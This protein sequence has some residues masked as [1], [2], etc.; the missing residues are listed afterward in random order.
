M[1]LDSTWGNEEVKRIIQNLCEKTQNGSISWECDEYNPASFLL[2]DEYGEG[3]ERKPC[4][5]HIVTL[6]YEP[7]GGARY[8]LEIGG[9]IQIDKNAPGSLH[10]KLS[11]YDADETL[12][13]QEETVIDE[14]EADDFGFIPLCGAVF[15]RAGEWLNEDSFT[16]VDDRHFYP[17]KGVTKK[18]RATPLC[19]L[20]E[21]LMNE[22][23]IG[24]FHRIIMDRPYRE[25]LISEL[26]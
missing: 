20:M 23:R 13:Y 1:G 15:E 12:L 3:D 26:K 10:P 21:Q 5:S 14:G 11:V 17:Q 7:S 8:I 19:R 2:G 25:R 22:R 6:V 24:D 4:V 9:S 18:H 16:Y